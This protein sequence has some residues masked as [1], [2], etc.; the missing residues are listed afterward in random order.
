M[1]VH[2]LQQ[3]ELA[4]LKI[5]EMLATAARERR[6]ATAFPPQA[7]RVFDLMSWLRKQQQ[8]LFTAPQSVTVDGVA[9]SRQQAC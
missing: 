3:E 8:K 7:H 9:A 6:V 1:L 5:E 4:K 2:Y